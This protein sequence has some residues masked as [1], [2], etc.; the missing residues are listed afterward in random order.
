MAQELWN[1]VDHYFVERLGIE[2][3]AL[4]HAAAASL[5][6]GLP[7]IQVSAA[8]GK[9]LELLVA[10]SRS[11]S[12]LEVGTL[13][14]YSTICLAR[15]VGPEGCVLS[16]ELEAHH[17][18][19]AR[20]NLVHA[21]LSDRVEVRVAPAL[22][23]LEALVDLGE[24]RFDFFF[25]DADKEGYPDYLER[26]LALSHPGS[27]IVVDNM[28]GAGDVASSSSTSS[29]TLAKRSM[30]DALHHHPGLSATAIQTV[31][32]KGYDGFVL[33]LVTQ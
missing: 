32:T 26:S 2:D 7:A 14:G 20:A 30:I 12:V 28:V 24:D 10:S 33:A 21:G 29:A 5:A 4:A 17:A 22:E 3:E 27:M 8:Q 15:G 25:I 1:E 23:S 6:A 13:G 18:E 16:L 19:V 31:G 11:R 9:L